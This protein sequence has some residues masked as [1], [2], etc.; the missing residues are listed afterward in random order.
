MLNYTHLL[1]HTLHSLVPRPYS[2]LFSV[3]QLHTYIY[4]W[5]PED[6]AT[7]C[8][9]S[10]GRDVNSYG[11]YAFTRMIYMHTQP[12]L[13]EVPAPTLAPASS[14]TPPPS[15]EGG[16]RKRPAPA[17]GDENLDPEDK[18]PKA[19]QPRTIEI[20]LPPSDTSQDTTGTYVCHTHNVRFIV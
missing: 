9:L 6:K 13:N 8:T 15:N 3:T 7:L 17:D 11:F 16:E 10:L 12:S 1:K 2:Q 19:K 14:E 18:A 20:E 5:E 4:Y